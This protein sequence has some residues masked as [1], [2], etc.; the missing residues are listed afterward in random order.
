MVSLYWLDARADG[1]WCPWRGR[2][3]IFVSSGSLPPVR[4]RLV[5]CPGLRIRS[6]D[7]PARE[8][9]K[10]NRK[11]GI[12]FVGEPEYDREILIT[13]E[14]RTRQFIFVQ[15]LSWTQNGGGGMGNTAGGQ[16][17]SRNCHF[18]QPAIQLMPTTVGAWA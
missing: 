4:K 7:K 18:P 8:S 6:G 15:I 3:I 12:H 13:K 2:D 14:L 10:Q 5:A 9:G 16:G 1:S 11:L 17:R